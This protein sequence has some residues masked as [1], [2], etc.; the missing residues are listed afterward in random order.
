MYEVK[1]GF[2]KCPHCAESIKE[3]A[4]KCRY[5]GSK[6]RNFSNFK[7]RLIN[8]K[9]D[10]NFIKFFVVLVALILIGFFIWKN[11]NLLSFDSLKSKF[12][13]LFDSGT[14][15]TL[16]PRQENMPMN[17]IVKIIINKDKDEESFGSG[18]L[19]TNDGHILT[20]AHV[21]LTF[22]GKPN[23]DLTVCF[24]KENS[25]KCDYGAK[26]IDFDLDNDL[27]VIKT[28]KPISE[29]HPY[30]LKIEEN[31]E[32]RIQ[33][34]IPLGEQINVLGY[35]GVSEGSLVVTRGIVSGYKYDYKFLKD[36]QPKKLP[37]YIKTD[38]EINYGNSGG[39]SFDKNNRFVGIPTFMNKDDGG[40][41]SYIIYWPK[42][43]K[44]LVELIYKNKI[45]IN[46]DQFVNDKISKEEVNYNN[47]YKAEKRKDY[48]IALE[49]IDKYLVKNKNAKG[50]YL[51]CKIFQNSN[52]YTSVK[53][54]SEELRGLN[55]SGVLTASFVFSTYGNMYG[56][57]KN[58]DKAYEYINQV[59]EKEPENYRYYLIKATI[60][61]NK[62]KIE[63]A[64]KT[65]EKAI[66]LNELS[67]E[68]WKIKGEI[69]RK[70]KKNADAVKY[71]EYS[72]YLKP[73]SYTASH[74]AE[75]FYPNSG[76][77]HE[78]IGKSL[79][80]GISSLAIDGNNPD[81]LVKVNNGI[82]ELLL[83]DSEDK[84]IGEKFKSIMDI[85]KK[86][87]LN[88]EIIDSIYNIPDKSIENY[89]KNTLKK[90]VINNELKDSSISYIQMLASW[91]YTFIG[92]KEIC[93]YNKFN[94]EAGKFIN[95][96][97]TNNLTKEQAVNN[98]YL[99]QAFQCFCENTD[100]SKDVLDKCYENKL[101]EVCGSGRK[102]TDSGDC[103]TP[104]EACIQML[105]LNSYAGTNDQCFCKDGSMYN[106]SKTKCVSACPSNSSYSNDKCYCNDGYEWYGDICV[107]YSTG[108]ALRYGHSW[109]TK[110][111]CY[112]DFGYQLNYNK[113]YCIPSY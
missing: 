92:E 104:G 90:D 73:T 42:I 62:D 28:D 36:G 83:N 56:E 15:Y 29:V 8:F 101:K 7:I 86:L 71:F 18:L 103:L 5:C 30:A 25:I 112:C 48:K 35:P 63:D 6:I 58:L 102:F 16:N 85:L 33:N 46:S 87:Q 3:D 38:S 50:L 89:I 2:K 61:Q 70:E 82:I 109:G 47:S 88:K 43:N 106:S 45:S 108:C 37:I 10:T 20:N 19:F 72:F 9:V 31:F 69:A 76:E 60:E 22:L 75:L 53:S 13:Q 21:I 65:N 51:K 110:Y 77:E 98:I 105:G 44:Y 12:F 52:D 32:N 26:I 64:K 81:V 24:N 74:L 54:C 67:P 68:A 111:S 107:T 40:K 14:T 96:L 23:D 78:D 94:N 1:M 93:S 100:Y 113:S 79:F 95:M 27:A 17:A 91:L 80:Y 57:E 49:E 11:F 84:T 59:I 41:L 39:G 4:I 99:N 97:M 55:N 66:K 34:E